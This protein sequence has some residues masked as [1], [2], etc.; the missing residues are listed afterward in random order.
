L[1]EKRSLEQANHIRVSTVSSRVTVAVILGNLDVVD[2]SV[3][4][5]WFPEEQVRSTNRGEDSS[6]EEFVLS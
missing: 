5:Q 1:A 3:H 6:K 4:S 2:K